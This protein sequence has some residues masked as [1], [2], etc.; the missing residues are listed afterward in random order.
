[1]PA[2]RAKSISGLSSARAREYTVSA[3]PCEEIAQKTDENALQKDEAAE[4]SNTLNNESENKAMNA[5]IKVEGMMCPNCE[6]R[7]KN[8]CEAVEGVTL[9]V[10]SHTDGTVT[11]EMSKDVSDEC[12]AAITAAGYDVV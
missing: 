5:V 3:V 8:A 4:E 7:V 1:M 11:L 9:V 2:L 12:R 6:A 10:A